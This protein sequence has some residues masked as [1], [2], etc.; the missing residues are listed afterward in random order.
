VR[1]WVSALV[2]LALVA[3]GGALVSR[4]PRQ[5]SLVLV[6]AEPPPG[7][8]PPA[9]GGPPTP[10]LRRLSGAGVRLPL[11]A[12]E[13]DA[14]AWVAEVLG[15]AGPARGP[16]AA[17]EGRGW[18]ALGASDLPVPATLEAR[19]RAFSGPGP[20]DAVDRLLDGLASADV[21][22]DQPALVVLVVQPDT[23][24]S[25][26]RSLSR[27]L[28]GIAPRVTLSRTL[29]VVVDRGERSAL[30]VAPERPRGLVVPAAL[31]PGELGVEIGRW[32]RL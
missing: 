4:A 26:D 21:R 23:P 12:P 2:A 3:V 11:A 25:W 16:L 27:L 5:W 7:A 24:A 9:P 32:L 13:R 15:D 29:V 28:D 19:F 17:W 10:R 22:P 6:V 1:R 31:G 20:G 14:G 8:L 30:L 18:P